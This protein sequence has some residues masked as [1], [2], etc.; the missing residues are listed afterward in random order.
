MTRSRSITLLAT[1]AVIPLTA[2]ALASCGG[3]GGGEATASPTP[4]KTASGRPA[5]VGL[6]TT[7]LGKI[8]VDSKGRTIYLFKKDSGTRSACS[9][10]CASAWPPV[11]A[12]GKPTVGPGAKASLVGI[13][14]RSEGRPQVT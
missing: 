7:G 13:T 3:G 4:P 9:G 14:A 1:A 5:T 8:L 10:A 11:R 6:A 2:L 12:N